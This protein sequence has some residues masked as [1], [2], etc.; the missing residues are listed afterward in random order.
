MQEEEP[1]T[2]GKRAAVDGRVD[3][4]KLLPD[5]TKGLARARLSLLGTRGLRLPEAPYSSCSAAHQGGVCLPQVLLGR[6]QE[7]LADPCRLQEPP[8]L[9]G[10]WRQGR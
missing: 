4:E 6:A 1:R 3:E 2:K 9:M 8:D 10:T 7:T 5:R